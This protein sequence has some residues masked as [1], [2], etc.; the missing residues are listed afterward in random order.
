MGVLIFIV[1]FCPISELQFLYY[2]NDRSI[3]GKLADNEVDSSLAIAPTLA[4]NE[5]WLSPNQESSTIGE[6]H[7]VIQCDRFIDKDMV[8]HYY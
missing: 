5:T 4:L 1:K 6:G 2:N 3:I 7:C 8:V